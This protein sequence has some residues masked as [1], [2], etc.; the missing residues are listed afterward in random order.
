M[1]LVWTWLTDPDNWHRSINGR[2]I[3][4]HVLK[5]LE[6]TGLT[7][8]EVRSERLREVLPDCERLRDERDAAISRGVPFEFERRMRRK[9]GQYR[10]LLIHFNPLR[11]E[12]GNVTRWYAKRARECMAARRWF[13]V[14]TPTLRV[15][16]RCVRNC[17]T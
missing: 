6:Y 15:R 17:R 10:W 16:S 11:D 13:L 12:A 7:K 8:E 9:D 2:G 3:P 4:Y 5:H 1:N 14:A